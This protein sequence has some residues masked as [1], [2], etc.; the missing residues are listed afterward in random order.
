MSAQVERDIARAETFTFPILAVL[1][2]IVFGSAVAA[3]LPLLTGAISNGVSQF[4]STAITS[5][6]AH[7]L[8]SLL[9]QASKAGLVG[10]LSGAAGAAASL[11]VARSNNRSAVK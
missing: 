9:T 4:V 2:L 10:M 8:L 6:D 7:D 1:L 5:K 11:A 3:G